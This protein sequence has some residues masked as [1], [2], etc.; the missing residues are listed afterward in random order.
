MKKLLAAALLAAT[1]F[2]AQ[3]ADIEGKWRTVDDKT[4][5]PKAIVQISKSG[6]AYSGRIVG[7]AAGVENHCAEC[8]QP[9]TLTGRW[10][11]RGLQPVEGKEGR[12]DKGTITDP[13]SGDSY[14]SKA[15]LSAD[16]RVLTVK[17]CWGVVC[18]SQRWERVN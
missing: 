15:K 7:V 6:N 5:K 14:K 4:K 9:G 10:V 16:G 17:G 11:V 8:K 3:A 13:K 1:A 2:A 12:F 18:R